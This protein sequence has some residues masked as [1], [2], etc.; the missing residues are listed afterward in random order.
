M[1][2]DRCGSPPT[3]QLTHSAPIVYTPT[4]GEACQKYSQIFSGPEGLYL[5][6][7]D[8]VRGQPP[9]LARQPILTS[10]TIS[11]PCSLLTD[12]L[13]PTRP[14]SSSS[15]MAHESS[16]SATSESEVWVSRSAS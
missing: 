15:P 2:A 10:R 13:S 8:K 5:S 12:P 3:Q 1:S 7:D 11:L 4:V 16:V 6:I 14:V 9:E